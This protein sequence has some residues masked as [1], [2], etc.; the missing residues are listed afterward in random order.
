MQNCLT[1]SRQ[2]NRTLLRVSLVS[3]LC[4][5]EIPETLRRR[6][7][8]FCSDRGIVA[9]GELAYPHLIFRFFSI[10]THQEH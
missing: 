7:V 4:V 6:E 5:F 2:N 10:N 8:T 3:S 1:L 9:L